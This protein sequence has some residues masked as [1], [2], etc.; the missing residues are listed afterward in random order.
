MT[1]DLE[2]RETAY[3][4]VDALY[5]EQLDDASHQRLV[6][7]LADDDALSLYVVQMNF[8]RQP[9]LGLSSKGRKWIA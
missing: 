6:T 1:F 4:L 8:T 9:G 3:G 2:Q 7:L 5:D